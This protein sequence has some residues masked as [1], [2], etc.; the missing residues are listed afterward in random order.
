MQ[1]SLRTCPCQKTDLAYSP[2]L[3]QSPV[4]WIQCVMINENGLNAG[5]YQAVS[6]RSPG[7]VVELCIFFIVLLEIDR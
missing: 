4:M 2:E 1:V 5:L 7:L 6:V 3:M